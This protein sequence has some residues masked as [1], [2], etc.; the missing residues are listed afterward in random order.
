MA[1]AHQRQTQHH[2]IMAPHR[3]P[4]RQPKRR[5]S[6][7]L[8]PPPIR[9]AA[10]PMAASRSC[11]SLTAWG[12]LHRPPLRP[13]GQPGLQIVSH[14]HAQQRPVGLAMLVGSRRVALA[15]R[16]RGGA[17][18]PR[19]RRRK[20]PV[21]L[22]PGKAPSRWAVNCSKIRSQLAFHHGCAATPVEPYCKLRC[23]WTAVCGPGA[24]LAAVG[25][26]AAKSWR[27]GH[28]AVPGLRSAAMR[29]WSR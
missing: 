12:P 29:A 10:G 19:S 11:C 28:S 8:P 25:R 4:H 17:A 5:R 13:H 26:A 22:S 23:D 1:R 18:A 21:L 15:Q 27:A 6:W 24:S 14:Q 7:R 2:R 3:R 16:L 9:S 20:M